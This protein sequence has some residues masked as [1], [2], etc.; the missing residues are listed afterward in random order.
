M[1]ITRVDLCFNFHSWFIIVSDSVPDGSKI[2]RHKN[3]KTSGH[4]ESSKL[5]CWQS[6]IPEQTK[7]SMI[8][9]NELF[10]YVPKKTVWSY[11]HLSLCQ[12]TIYNFSSNPQGELQNSKH[13]LRCMWQFTPRPWLAHLSC[14]WAA[15]NSLQQLGHLVETSNIYLTSI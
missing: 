12:I 2:R 1:N 15:C 7:P 8:F 5:S 11:F 3:N 4:L 10:I 9:W 14:W 6:I 13:I